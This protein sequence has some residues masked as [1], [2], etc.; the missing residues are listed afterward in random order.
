MKWRRPVTQTLMLLVMRN[1]YGLMRRRIPLLGFLFVCFIF[2]AC[3][4]HTHVKGYVYDTDENPIKYALVTLEYGN[5]KFEVHS[6]KDGAYD[7]GLVHGPFFAGL[8]LRATKEGYEPFKLSFSSNSG[9]Q[10]YYKIVLK[11]VVPDK[12][13]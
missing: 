7:V 6:D 12:T 4:G 2:A 1:V 3:D 5:Q 9:P 13:K 8:T 10:G 11:R